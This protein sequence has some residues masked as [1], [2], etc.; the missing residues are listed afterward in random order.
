LRG[1]AQHIFGSRQRIIEALQHFHFAMMILSIHCRR[2]RRR[3]QRHLAAA[4]S[5]R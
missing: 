4:I 1:A 5:F 3:R 2:Q